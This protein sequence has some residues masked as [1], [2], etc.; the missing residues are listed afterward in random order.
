[1]KNNIFS[2]CLLPILLAILC[3]S[4]HIG[5]LCWRSC[6]LPSSQ[7]HPVDSNDKCW[8]WRR[9]DTVFCSWKESKM[10]QDPLTYSF[11]SFLVLLRSNLSSAGRNLPAVLS[12]IAAFLLD[13]SSKAV[14][15]AL[16]EFLCCFHGRSAYNSHSISDIMSYAK[17]SGRIFWV[18]KHRLI[19]RTA[20]VKPIG[21]SESV[22]AIHLEVPLY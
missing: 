2:F 12:L 11:N 15:F 16:C 22:A 13:R 8:K 1:M 7:P 20:A 5:S 21:F 10:V 3:S 14:F 17:I 19:G 6:S 18:S 4:D 9:L